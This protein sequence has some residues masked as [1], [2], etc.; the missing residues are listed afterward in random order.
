MKT[1]VIM[2]T[3]R[4]KMTIIA[5]EVEVEIEAEVVRVVDIAALVIKINQ[6]IKL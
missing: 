1:I 5:V 4:I 6:H 3:M 2:I